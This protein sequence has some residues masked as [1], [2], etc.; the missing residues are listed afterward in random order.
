MLFV[1]CLFLSSNAQA[2]I[3][4][5]EPAEP[6]WGQTLT[7]I[8]DASAAGAK[9]AADDE[10]FVTARWSYPGY[11]ENAWTR[12]TRLGSRFTCELPVRQNANGV[13]V[14]FV[15]LNG[16]WDEAAYTTAMIYRADGKPARG[17]FENRIKS[18]RYREFFEKEIALY[19]DNYSAYRAKW[20]MAA[21]IENDGGVKVVKSDLDKLLRERN[22]SADLLCAQSTA[23][24]MQGREEQGRE[25]VRRA[26]EKFPDDPLTATAVREYERLVAD[27]GLPADGLA[28]I[29]KMKRAIIARNPQTEFARSV[30]STLVEDR[31]APLDLLETI[32]QSW[33]NA[34]PENP[35]PWFN[36]AQALERQYQKPERA[37]QLIEKAIELLRAGKLRLYGD[38]NGRQTDRLLLSA[39]VIKGEIAS[40]QGK[41][42]LALAA[43]ATAK[44]LSPENDFRAFLIEARV[45]GAMNQNDRAESAFIE[46]WRRGSKEADDRV[47][48]IYKAKRGTLEGYDEYLLGRSKGRESTND[49][50][51]LPAPQFKVTAL[52]GKT[53]DLKSLRGKIV[54]LNMWFI[55]C[56]PCRKEIP[57]LNAIA[58]EFKTRDVVF[59][60]PAPDLPDALKDFLKT[61]AFD[62][63]IVPQADGLLDLFNIAHFPTHIVIDREGQVELLMVGARQRAPEEVRRVLLQMQR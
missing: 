50:W 15:T 49:G 33:M 39:Y 30:S 63:N 55:G 59:L 47:R 53:Y 51:K 40:R 18:E 28:E 60:A 10:T 45:L 27:L 1:F 4:R 42:D 17:A 25:R 41:N 29:A 9:L 6:R 22:E 31:N 57:A 37:A 12:M 8:Y 48:A 11:S 44:Q 46:A 13:A 16:G 58:R 36:L 3:S 5:I 61:T 34:E 23:Y 43:L 24:L 38:V 26:F 21:A 2:Q 35:Q 56:G 32:S 14:H 52:D 19:P 54:V 20:A 62:Y 7:L